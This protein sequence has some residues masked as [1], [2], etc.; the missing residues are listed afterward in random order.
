[1]K[2]PALFKTSLPST[3]K[4]QAEIIWLHGW[5]QTHKSLL[6]LA[7]LFKR[8]FKNTLYDLPGFG[9]SK[10]LEAGAGTADYAGA[11]IG[12]LENRKSTPVVLVGHS[13]GC[14]VA[15]R[16][17]AK[18]PDLVTGLVLIAAAGL[19][20][21][22]GVGFR[23]KG[24]FLKILGKLAGALDTVFKTGFKARYRQ[25]FGS[26]D[27]REAGDL[28]A[29][30]IKTVKEDLSETAKKV[31]CPAL[32]LYGSEDMETPPELG[33]KFRALIHHADLKI[34]NGFD[35]LGILTAGQ[36]QCQHHMMKFLQ[37]LEG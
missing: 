8:G 7:G 10:M 27:Y 20:R 32:L 36:H 24:F 30:F 4:N 11:L 18:R 19:P 26:R 37:E 25:R 5:G 3:G 29:T 22:R 2:N 28:L 17:A 13:F 6:S 12:E 9:A 16:L 21:K 14:R 34:L 35:H 33:L 15:I 1:M 23:I 31:E